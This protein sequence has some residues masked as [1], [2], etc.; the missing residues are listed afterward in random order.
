MITNID[1]ALKYINVLIKNYKESL[2]EASSGTQS[3]IIQEELDECLDDL[4]NLKKISPELF[5]NKEFVM[6]AME[7]GY[8]L[9]FKNLNEEFRDD[10]DLVLHGLRNTKNGYYFFD[11]ITN[12]LKNNKDFMIKAIEINPKFI[13]FI[14]D[15][16]KND[17]EFLENAKNTIKIYNE[18]E[19]EERFKENINKII[20]EQDEDEYSDPFTM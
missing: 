18:K 16:L 14:G 10:K 12:R 9:Y 2:K 3:L 8:F 20:K 6:K 4:R 15:N 5:L 13:N 1:E 7:T 19:K 11:S 17:S